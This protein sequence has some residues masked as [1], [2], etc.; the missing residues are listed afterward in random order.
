M[1]SCYFRH[2]YYCH[3]HMGLYAKPVVAVSAV[4][5]KC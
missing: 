2:H 1:F 5:T 4:E 3:A